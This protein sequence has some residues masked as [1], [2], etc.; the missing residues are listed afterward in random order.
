MNSMER[1]LDIVTD[2]VQLIK[3]CMT[4]MEEA[5]AGFNRRTD[6]I[7]V[8]WGPIDRRLNLTDA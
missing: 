8:G 2:D 1:K 6:N 4:D 7:E 5:M 3:V